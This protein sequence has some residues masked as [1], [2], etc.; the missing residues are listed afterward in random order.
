MKHSKLYISAMLFAALAAT[1]CDDNWD[2]P[3]MVAPVATIEAN[4]SIEELK[5]KYWQEANNCV[6]TIGYKEDGKTHYIIK[7]RVVS[8]DESGNIYK[9]LVI[10]DTYSEAGETPSCITFS[11]NANSL[12]ASYRPGQEVVIDATDMYIG[13]YSGLQQFGLPEYSSSFGWQTT[14]RRNQCLEAD[15][16]KVFLE[17]RRPPSDG[18]SNQTN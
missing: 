3:P 15:A 13:K 14:F 10:Q 12:Y 4:T 18:A 16:V 5:T 7:G 1:S 17:K 11:I 9:N 8:S 2:T 6:D